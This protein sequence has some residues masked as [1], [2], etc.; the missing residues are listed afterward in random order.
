MRRR[1]T[2]EAT[3]KPAPVASRNVAEHALAFSGLR[4][5]LMRSA[6]SLLLARETVDLPRR[7]LGRANMEVFYLYITYHYL[8]FWRATL[9]D[10]EHYVYSV[11]L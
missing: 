11:G 4:R 3:A 5:P 7:N 9:D 10:D 8:I 6:A 1:T 2:G